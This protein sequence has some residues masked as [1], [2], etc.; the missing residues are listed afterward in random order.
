MLEVSRDGAAVRNDPYLPPRA[1][2]DLPPPR[3]RVSTLQATAARG[4][5]VRRALRQ[6]YEAGDIT[7]EQRREWRRAYNRALRTRA[8]LTGARRVQL[9]SQIETLEA[10]ARAEGLDASRMPAL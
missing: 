2:T 1:A 9:S 5:T 7:A 6:A 8:D 3:G 4:P 10:I